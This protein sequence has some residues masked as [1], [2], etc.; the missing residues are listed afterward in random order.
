MSTN[1]PDYLFEAG[2]FVSEIRKLNSRRDEIS[3]EPVASLIFGKLWTRF[4][5]LVSGFERLEF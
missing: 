2:N 1:F 5:K 3:L 4:V